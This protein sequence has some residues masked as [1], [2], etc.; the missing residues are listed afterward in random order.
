VAASD[1]DEVVKLGLAPLNG[2]SPTVGTVGYT[3]GGGQSPTLGRSFGYAADHVRAIELVT[4]DGEL[5]RVTAER[6]PDLFWALRGGK[7]NFGVVTALEFDLFP[8]SQLYGGGLFFPGERI[9]DVLHTWRKWVA[10][11]PQ[12]MTSSVAVQRLPALSEL[13]NQLRGAFVVHLRIAYLGSAADGEQ[14]AAPL[15]AIAPALLDTGGEMPYAAVAAIHMDPAEP[16]PYYDRTTSLRELSEQTVDA[17]I[18]LTGPDSDCPLTSVE[19][20][21]LGGAFDRQPAVPNA[22]PTRGI[23][24]V[25]FGFGVGGPEQADVMR[26]YLARMISRLEPWASNRRFVNFLSDDE[27]TNSEQVRTVYGFDRYERLAAVKKAYDPFNMFRV[28]HNI[29]PATNGSLTF[30]ENVYGIDLP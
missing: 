10:D 24:F 13:P 27:A 5:R 14:L 25:V 8:V 16:V 4:A 20:R 22:V 29:T 23:P 3:L 21:S 17:L 12:E 18:D 1:I 11:I 9:A 15:R 7:G 26:H 30:R 6:E 28:N 2:S 19:I